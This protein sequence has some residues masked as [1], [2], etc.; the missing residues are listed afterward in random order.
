[1]PFASNA[2]IAPSCE[3]SMKIFCK[4][5]MQKAELSRVNLGNLHIFLRKVWRMLDILEKGQPDRSKGRLY[6]E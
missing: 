2:I 3:K 1:M 5:G 6:P 4:N